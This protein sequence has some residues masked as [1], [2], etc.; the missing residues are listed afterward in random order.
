MNVSVMFR[1][2]KICR[3][4]MKL[5]FRRDRR[6]LQ[7]LPAW[8]AGSGRHTCQDCRGEEPALRRRFR[9]ISPRP[10]ASVASVPGSGTWPSPVAAPRPV[11]AKCVGGRNAEVV[12]GD[13]V[14]AQRT[15]FQPLLQL[16]LRDLTEQ[17]ASARKWLAAGDSAPS[18]KAS[19][20]SARNSGPPSRMRQYATSSR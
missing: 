11:A 9:P 2:A 8:A 16:R 19:V 1:L 20:N 18:L 12:R 4:T 13:L 15:R 6:S 17:R 10:S 14:H 7:A 3:L 5:A